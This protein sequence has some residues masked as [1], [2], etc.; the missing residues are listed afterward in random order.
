MVPPRRTAVKL[1]LA[2]PGGRWVIF[3]QVPRVVPEP[4]GGIRAIVL[5]PEA[6]QA[7]GR[8]HEVLSC[9]YGKAQPARG[10]DPK[11]M[12]ARYEEH[13]AVDRT[14]LGDDAVR[15]IAD[16]GGRLPTWSSVVEQIPGRPFGPDLGGA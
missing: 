12:R 5:V 6:S 9:R 11:E 1:R 16:G 3:D 14:D 4:D 15:S 10:E 13:V 7:C 2:W 8:G